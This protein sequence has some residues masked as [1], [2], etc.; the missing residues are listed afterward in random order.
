MHRD[1]V[2]RL[3][4]AVVGPAVGLL[5]RVVVAAGDPRAADLELAHRLAVPGQ[6]LSVVVAVPQLDERERD[7]L[8]GD[9]VELRVLV[10][11]REVAGQ[12]GRRGDRRGL[13][14]PPAVH[15]V[16]AVTLLEPA[17]IARGAA[18]PPTSMPFIRER[19]YF[20]GSASSIARMP[21]Q[22]VGTPAVQ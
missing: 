4:P 19:S 2:T 16:Q 10:G 17:I 9:V 8:H 6:D 3:E 21:S 11:G 7:P 14:H 18:E 5:G 13:G 20:P 22:I 15:D 12:L 1:D